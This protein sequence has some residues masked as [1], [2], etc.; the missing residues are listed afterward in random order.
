MSFKAIFIALSISTALVVAAFMLHQQ[1]PEEELHQPTM[2]LVRAS[3]KCAQCHR[4]ETAA[5]VR[6]Y[7][8]S[9]HAAEEVNCLDCHSPAEEQESYT[10]RGFVIT[11]NPTAK[12]CYQCHQTEYDQYLRSRHA[13]P[14]WAAVRGAQDFNQEQIAHAEK[15]HPGA[16]ERTPNELALLEGPAAAEVGCLGCHSVGK[17]NRDGS[18]GTCS[19]CHTRH[20]ASVEQARTPR[21]CGQ[22]HM[23]PDHSQI[24]IYESSKHGVIF[25]VQSDMMNMEV[26]PKEL[27]TE[28]MWVPTCS[29]CHMSGLE[30]MGVTHDTTERLSYWLFA[31]VSDRRPHYEHAQVQMKSVCQKCH[32]SESVDQFYEDAESVVRATNRK[33]REARDLMDQLHQEGLLSPQSFD[34]PLEYEYFDLW[35]YYGR[36]AKHGAFMG[37][38]DFV[39]WHGN[40]ELLRKIIEMKHKAKELRRKK[41]NPNEE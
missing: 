36:T 3:G 35:H 17:P 26:P 9:R 27:G 29:T 34:E 1:R 28:D 23:G 6:E 24:E 15:F 20:N 39:Q 18:I 4:K 13:A 2:Q 38:A 5:V 8:M 32:S 16:V 41:R 21:T 10:H 37:G 7:E 12:N 31:A 40:Y 33:V 19:A 30:G 22:C 25:E 11:K 14:A